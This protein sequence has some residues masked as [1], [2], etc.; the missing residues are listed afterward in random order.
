MQSWERQSTREAHEDLLRSALPRRVRYEVTSKVP[1]RSSVKRASG[2][3]FDAS[4]CPAFYARRSEDPSRSDFGPKV[5]FSER[6]FSETVKISSRRTQPLLLSTHKLFGLRKSPTFDPLSQGPR[7]HFWRVCVCRSQSSEDISF[8]FSRS[9]PFRPKMA[10]V[11]KS[12][13]LSS[14]KCPPG[15]HRG[16]A[17]GASEVLKRKSLRS[18]LAPTL[19][20]DRF[21]AE[22]R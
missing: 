7:A 12:A 6:N 13:L 22:T 9:E 4:S 5:Y 20:D 10:E 17:Q 16:D 8:K 11:R 19:R 21:G 3:R 2:R 18:A 14:Q 1:L 15:G